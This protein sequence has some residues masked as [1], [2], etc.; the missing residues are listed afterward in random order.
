VEPA[1]LFS[2]D[3]TM[4]QR[5]KGQEVEIVVLE[6]GEPR[7]NLTFARSVDLRF[8]TELKEEGYL[9]ETTN[10]YDSIFNG[11]GGSLEFHFDSPE[12][13]NIIRSLVNKARRRDGQ[14]TIN[15]KCTINFPSGRRARCVVRDAEFG[16]LPVS[17]GSRSDYGTFRLE[18][19]ASEAQVLP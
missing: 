3:T 12:P 8:K 14:T 19:G 9:G 5:V 11:V 4:G 18:F 6:N 13:F 17:F 2:E 15:I 7:E 10:R 16:E 1:L